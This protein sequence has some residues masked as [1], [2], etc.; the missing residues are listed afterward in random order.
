MAEKWDTPHDSG[1]FAGSAVVAAATYGRRH[2]LLH[3]KTFTGELIDYRVGDVPDPAGA[4]GLDGDNL[5][6]ISVKI[7]HGGRQCSVVALAA[8]G[9]PRTLSVTIPA[10]LALC[11]SGVH[12]VVDGGLPAGAP[13]SARKAA[14]TA[15]Q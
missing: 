10:A 1:P 9:G 15:Q 5:R 7:Q 11:K 3:L 4:A 8:A 2:T 14:S 12:A 13:C 6:P